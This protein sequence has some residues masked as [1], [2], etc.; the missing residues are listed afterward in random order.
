VGNAIKKLRIIRVIRA[1]DGTESKRVEIINNQQVIEAYDRIRKN[2]D[3]DF[4]KVYAQMDDEYKEE[5]RKEKR[6]LQD[7]LRRI[8]R[9]ETKVNSNNQPQVGRPPK[10]KTDK[11]PVPIKPSLLKMKCS[12]CGETG[13]MK[14]N[15]NC[16]MYG[17]NAEK[18]K[19]KTI[20]DIASVRF[21]LGGKKI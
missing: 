21:F 12:A 11:K 20:G 13:H 17:K 9:N 19:E 4:I 7:Q 16:P 2:R 15:K 6:R 1:P 3:N 5:R 10:K 18:K 14:T 8:K